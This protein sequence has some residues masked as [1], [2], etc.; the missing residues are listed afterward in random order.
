MSYRGIRF[1]FP[2]EAVDLCRACLLAVLIL[3][4][5]MTLAIRVIG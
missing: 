1:R 5:L 4:G 2:C 3:A